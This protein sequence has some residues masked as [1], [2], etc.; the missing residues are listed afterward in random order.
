MATLRFVLS[1]LAAARVAAGGSMGVRTVHASVPGDG[2]G[3]PHAYEFDVQFPV[4]VQRQLPLVLMLSG[5]C[6][7]ADQQDSIQLRYS[8]LVHSH[9]FIYAPLRSARV[10]RTCSL[11]PTTVRAADAM[12]NMP[13]YSATA[14]LLE[15][16]SAAGQCTAWDATSAC[17]V[18]ERAGRDGGDVPL[19][20]AVIAKVQSIA[21]V[22]ST[23]IYVVGIANGGFMALRL[24]CELGDQLA[25]VVAYASSLYS[26]QCARTHGL[27]PLLHV[28]GEIDVVVPFNGGY[29]SAG[30]P[31]PGFVE[32]NQIWA[33]MAGCNSGTQNSSFV[34]KGSSNDAALTVEVSK[35]TGCD[36]ERWRIS[37]GQHFALPATSAVI[38]QKALTDFLL[39]RR[40]SAKSV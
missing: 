21:P 12:Q 20:Q 24:A 27:P 25:G 2:H 9:G 22:D 6:L 8:D 17:C 14:R 39:P 31:F 29:N 1:A 37:N 5:F 32:S 33:G 7:P 11:C 30:V 3:L 4:D 28:W 36:L 40:P 10:A 23:R 35:Y 38:F 15:V 19:I 26:Q 34:A 13:L 16:T 18:P